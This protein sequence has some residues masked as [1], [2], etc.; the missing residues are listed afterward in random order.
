MSPEAKE[1]YNFIM[2]ILFDENIQLFNQDILLDKYDFFFETVMK[3]INK[4]KADQ[5]YPLS[6]LSSN[7]FTHTFIH[8]IGTE[9]IISKEGIGGVFR[10]ILSY[11][12]DPVHIYFCHDYDTYYSNFFDHYCQFFEKYFLHDVFAHFDSRVII[13]M[14]A[15][16]NIHFCILCGDETNSKECAING[17]VRGLHE[18]YLKLELNK[19]LLDK[20]QKGK[21]FCED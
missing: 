9:Y 16:D 15:K 10:N 2:E 4:I 7:K 1:L 13:H 8:T 12:I 19:E 21:I 18:S 17:E 14:Y 11:I 5:Q 20:Y 6:I 3:T